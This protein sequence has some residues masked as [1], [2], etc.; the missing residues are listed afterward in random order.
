MDELNSFLAGNPDPREYKRALAVKMAL[1]GY[2]YL[3]IMS[4]LREPRFINRMIGN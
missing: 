1:Q 3:E 4:L 2:P